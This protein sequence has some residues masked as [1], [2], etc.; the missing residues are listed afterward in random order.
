MSVSS[1]AHTKT[2]K[3]EL[4][5]RHLGLCDYEKTWRDMQAFNEKR[6][7]KTPDEIWFLQ[8]PSVYTLG[9]NGKPEHIL[10]HTDIPVIK[11]D[12]GGQVTYHGPGQL[13]CYI[14]LDITRFGIGVKKLVWLLE[15]SV[16]DLLKTFDIDGTRRQNAPGVYV[17]DAKIAALGLRVRKHCSYHGLSLNV[18]MNLNPFININ[19]CGYEDLAV[20]QLNNLG[21]REDISLIQTNLQKHLQQLLLTTQAAKINE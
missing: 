21:V 8:H 4:I 11:C 20:T 1:V 17:D 16:I 2:L 12:R 18:D 19:P 9:L 3:D 7:E 15:Q 10:K 14:L 6:D 5:I 13:I